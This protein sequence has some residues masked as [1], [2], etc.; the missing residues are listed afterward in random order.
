MAAPQRRIENRAPTNAKI[1][2][3]SVDRPEVCETLT[4]ENI[5]R[6]GA[7]ALTRVLWKQDDRVLVQSLKGN[8]RAQGR[9][10]YCKAVDHGGGFAV[11]L[12]FFSPTGKWEE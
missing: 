7:R 6:S 12:E 9:I 4:V 8:F 2:V 3:T 10:V 5:S 11:G 1:L